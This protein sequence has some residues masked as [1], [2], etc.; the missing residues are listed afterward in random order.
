MVAPFVWQYPIGF[1][2]WQDMVIGGVILALSFS[3]ALSPARYTGWL[4]IFVGAYSM[5]AP[6]IHG[7]LMVADALF[8]DLVFGV[9]TVATGVAIGAAGLV[10]REQGQPF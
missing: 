9:L 5:L 3:F 8:N 4:I 7:Y 6:F 1:I 2:V 10:Y